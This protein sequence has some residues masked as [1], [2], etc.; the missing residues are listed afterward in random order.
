[1]PEACGLVFQVVGETNIAL[2]DDFNIENYVSD[3]RTTPA[4]GLIT[5]TFIPTA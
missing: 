2:H 1:L 4:G 5:E 3:P